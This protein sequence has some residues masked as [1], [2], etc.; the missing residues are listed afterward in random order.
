M[1]IKTCFSTGQICQ[2]CLPSEEIVSAKQGMI[3]LK[4]KMKVEQKVNQIKGY[5]HPYIYKQPRQAQFLT[6]TSMELSAK[7][8]IIKLKRLILLK[9]CEP[10][11]KAR[12][13]LSKQSKGLTMSE[14]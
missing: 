4:L 10:K 8:K 1:K 11:F 6:R 12:S 2:S 3:K 7:W 13:N 9:S 14:N 5:K